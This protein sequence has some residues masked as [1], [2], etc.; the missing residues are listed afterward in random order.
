M[1]IPAVLL[2]FLSQTI[3]PGLNNDVGFTKA[4]LLLLPGWNFLLWFREIRLYLFFIPSWILFGVIAF[5]KFI[6][7]VTG[8]DNGQ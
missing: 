5:I 8:I 6:L 7:L 4:M 2:S 1:F 3:I